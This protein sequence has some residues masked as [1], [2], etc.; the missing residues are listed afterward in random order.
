MFFILQMGEIGEREWACE[1]LKSDKKSVTTFLI[2]MI[3][4]KELGL[5]DPV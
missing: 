1:S 2:A 4:C 5:G 3:Y